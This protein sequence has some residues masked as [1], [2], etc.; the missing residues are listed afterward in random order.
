MNGSCLSTSDGTRWIHE[1]HQHE[2]AS[3]FRRS[4]ATFVAFANRNVDDFNPV[5]TVARGMQGSELKAE[6]GSELVFWG[7]SLDCQRT[8]PFGTP[9]EVAQEVTEHLQTFAPGSGYVF[10]SVHNI[11]ALVPVDNVVTMFDTARSF[12]I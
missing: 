8:L 5:Q 1:S 11:Q 6:F 9:E 7:A 10:A 2:S 4:T 3:A 12:A